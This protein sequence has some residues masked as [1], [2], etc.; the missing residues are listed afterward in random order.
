VVLTGWEMRSPAAVSDDGRVVFGHAMC[1]SVPT[2]YRL[3][4]PN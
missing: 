3:V 4:I 2:L 1:G